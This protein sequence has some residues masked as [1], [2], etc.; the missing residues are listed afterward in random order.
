[1][2]G[3]RLGKLLVRAHVDGVV[4]F[5]ELDLHNP[6]WHRRLHLVLVELLRQDELKGLELLHRRKLTYMLCNAGDPDRYNKLV[7]E[8]T[9]LT[10][11]YFKALDNLSKDSSDTVKNKLGKR[12]FAAWA[13][14][15]GDPTDPDVQRRIE[16][17]AAAL[18]RQ[19]IAKEGST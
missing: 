1:M 18:K 15:F 19:R 3:H 6:A 5:K 17:T 2:A 10:E 7:E 13:S 12:L 9:Q 4:D 16:A 8:E 11:D 14:E